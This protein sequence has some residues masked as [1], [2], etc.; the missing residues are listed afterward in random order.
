MVAGCCSRFRYH[1][2]S[3][4]PGGPASPRRARTTAPVQSFSGLPVSAASSGP[5]Q[6]RPTRSPSRRQNASPVSRTVGRIP[7]LARQATSAIAGSSSAPATATTSG[8]I[9]ASRPMIRHHANSSPTLPPASWCRRHGQISS[10]SQYRACSH[11]RATTACATANTASGSTPARA[12][13][14][15]TPGHRR[16]AATTSAAPRRSRCSSGWSASASSSQRPCRTHTRCQRGTYR[17]AR[18]AC[19]VRRAVHSRQR[20]RPAPP[21]CPPSATAPAPGRPPARY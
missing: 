12:A 19:P 16:C 18:S 13:R 9:A 10:C 11:Q 14:R 1:G 7:P 15:A 6:S 5:S 17:T 2:S 20:T 8:K 4:H 21:P 3:R